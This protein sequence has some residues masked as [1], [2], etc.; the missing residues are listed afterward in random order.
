MPREVYCHVPDTTWPGWAA[1]T[2]I[3]HA[4]LCSPMTLEAVLSWSQGP[5]FDADSSLPLRK[6]GKSRRESFVRN[7]LA[8]MSL[9]GEVDFSRGKWRRVREEKSR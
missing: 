4:R 3:L 1:A 5:R 9:R 2:R 8:W 7:M 6:M